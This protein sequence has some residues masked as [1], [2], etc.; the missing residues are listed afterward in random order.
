MTSRL[1]ERGDGRAYLKPPRR[2][3]FAPDAAGTGP[4]A[5]FPPGLFERPCIVDTTMLHTPASGGVKRYLSTKRTW[6]AKH[7]PGLRHAMVLPARRNHSDGDGL[8]MV[9]APPLPFA[10]GYR[11]P[12]SVK[13]WTRRI[14][15]Q[16]PALIEAGDPY[17]PGMAALRA[18]DR[19]G[20][21][22][23]VFC[24]SDLAAIAALHLGAWAVGPARRYWIGAC[25]RFDAVLAP[26]A[27]LTASLRDAGIDQA[28]TAPLG[29]DVDVFRPITGARQALRR[30]LGLGE[31][32]RLLVFAGRPAPEK[33]IATLIKTVD[34]LGDGYRL[35]L[36]G[37]S[38]PD[39]ASRRILALPYEA[40]SERLAAVLAGC[41][42][43]VHA[44]PDETLGL[45]VLEAMACGLPVVG[46]DAGGVGETVDESFGELAPASTVSAL[47]EAITAL[48]E[49]DQEP[50]RSAARTR[51]VSRHS[52]DSAFGHLTGIYAELTG[53]EA[54]NQGVEIASP[55]PFLA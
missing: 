14:I 54:F 23:V 21:P 36:V 40:D 33:R 20:V 25:A 22:A 53:D 38:Q 51:A 52:W 47:A 12:L 6:L 44:N 34:R 50:L 19:L 8:W 5:A 55:P 17:V 4:A 28:R 11:L 45:V 29:V 48:F 37:C 18:G 1:G 2:K 30:R 49:R 10:Q 26:S 46:V 43:F 3:A 24:H 42:A 31:R 9:Q 27:Y 7:R 35:L 39:A 32:E 13:A 16:R 41:D 15:Q